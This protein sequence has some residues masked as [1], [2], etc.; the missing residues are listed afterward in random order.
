MARQSSVCCSASSESLLPDLAGTFSST[1]GI[2][3]G[4]GP[5]GTR[6][7]RCQST[8]TRLRDR[9]Q[10][11]AKTVGIGDLPK[12]VKG[13]SEGFLGRILGGALSDS[14]AAHGEHARGPDVRK[15]LRGQRSARSEPVGRALHQSFGS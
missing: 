10:P 2:G 7:R 6:F 3:R 1:A 4:C 12:F 5:A 14:G 8:Q 13:F 15:L 9:P 11:A